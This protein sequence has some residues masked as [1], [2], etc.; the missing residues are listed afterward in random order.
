MSDDPLENTMNGAAVEIKLRYIN[1]DIQKHEKSIEELKTHKT[2]QEGL[3][4]SFESFKTNMQDHNIDSRL[5]TLEGNW[6]SQKINKGEA[7]QSKQSNMG[8][9]IPVGISVL[10]FLYTMYKETS[11]S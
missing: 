2:T 4:K 9:W 10:L 3:N 5:D 8:L 6:K 7:L 11:G 1:K